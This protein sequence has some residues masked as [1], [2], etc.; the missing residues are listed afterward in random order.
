MAL[1]EVAP[2]K[3]EVK[4]DWRK[5]IKSRRKFGHIM[6]LVG[7][8]SI[9]LTGFVAA[10]MVVLQPKEV[11]KAV[12]KVKVERK[13]EATKDR[14]KQFNDDMD[15]DEKMAAVERN[16]KVVAEAMNKTAAEISEKNPELIEG[17]TAAAKRLEELQRRFTGVK[18]EVE[19][20]EK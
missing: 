1:V 18:I 19:K 2:E 17:F 10:L 4:E 15:I 14:F 3:P 13:V 12:V 11:A 16:F 8:S 7:V 5:D 20:V 6:L 9:L